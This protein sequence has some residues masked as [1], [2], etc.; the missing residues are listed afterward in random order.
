MTDYVAELQNIRFDILKI[1]HYIPY[2]NTEVVSLKNFVLCFGIFY[3]NCS[4][5]RNSKIL[6]TF[7]FLY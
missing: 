6:K 7:T 1:S 2:K 3:N 4:S 5:Y